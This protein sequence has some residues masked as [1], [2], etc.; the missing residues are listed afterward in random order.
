M[1]RV[2][3]AEAID[4]AGMA[5][6]ALLN[7]HDFVAEARGVVLDARRQ[8]AGIVAEAKERAL[9]AERSA[10]ERGY[11]DGYARGRSEAL[12]EARKLATAEARE[13]IAADGEALAALARQVIAAVADGREELLR[14]GRRQILGFALAVAEKI[15]GRVAVADICTAE[16]NLGK[17]LTL[18]DRAS[19]ATVAVNPEQLARLQRQLPQVVEAL[20]LRG[21]IEMVGDE[22]ISPGGAKLVGRSGVIDGTIQAQLDSVV[23]ALLG[24][25]EVAEARPWASAAVQQAAR[26]AGPGV[27]APMVVDAAAAEGQGTRD[28]AV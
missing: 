18:G 8:S 21:Q 1:D 12:A 28:G 24:R 17:V 25:A 19:A 20:G 2:I 4:S 13:R 15:V 6:A 9:E 14:Q 11:A 5:R 7:L 3:K 16:E 27:F 26:H 10:A 23:Q 22:S